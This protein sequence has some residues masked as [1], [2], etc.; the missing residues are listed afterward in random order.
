MEKLNCPNCGAPITSTE[1]PYCGTVFYDF[2]AISDEK[3]TYIKLNA[4]RQLLCFRARMR[5]AEI[6]F[7]SD[8]LPEVRIDFTVLPDD[9]G[10]LLM[11]REE[12]KQ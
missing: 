1:C 11:R 10:V 6:E 4:N 8:A 3:P 7:A 5:T 2:T 12:G 9:A